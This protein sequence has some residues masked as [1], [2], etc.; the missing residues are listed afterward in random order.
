MK[1]KHAFHILVDNFTVTYKQLLYRVII[2]VVA[3]GIGW[4]VLTPFIRDF[5]QS[6]AFD[7]LIGGIRTFA[8]DLLGGKVESLASVSENISEAY[9]Q[10]IALFQTRIAEVV[11]TGLLLFVLLIV[12]KWFTGL[13][14]YT[15]AV[16]INDKMSLRTSSPFIGTLISHFKEAALFNLIYVPLSVIYD[17]LVAAALFVTLF[18]MLKGIQFFFVSVFIFALIMVLATAIKM[19]FTCDWLPALI[20]GKMGHKKSIIYTFSQKNKHTFNVFSNFVV[21]LIMVIAVNVVAFFFT[22]GVG[23]LLSL[24]ASYVIII[25]FEM[26]NYYEREELRYF[27]DKNTI[28]KPEKEFTITRE[29]FFKGTD[30][31]QEP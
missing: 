22:F 20:R 7:N 13:G 21:I 19:T 2:F 28:I 1:F 12:E 24:P 6:D 30:F 29:Q 27:L 5:L 10:F 25:S 26:V 31:D 18:F 8:L 23:F 9:E 3:F 14:N 4:G 16:I 15:T 11:L 17:I